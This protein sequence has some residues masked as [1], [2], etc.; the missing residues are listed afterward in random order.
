MR[1]FSTSLFLAVMVLTRAGNAMA[2]PIRVVTGPSSVGWASDGDTVFLVGNGF[3]IEAGQRF[4]ALPA[5]AGGGCLGTDIAGSAT[6]CRPGDLVNQSA[7]TGGEV[8]LGP[9]LA[10]IDGHDYG[11]VILRGALTFT[12]T[13]APFPTPSADTVFMRAPFVFDGLIRGF[14]DGREVFSL[15]LIG[16]GTTERSFFLVDD[17]FHY[18][19]ESGVSYRF[20]T[21]SVSPTP[22]PASLVLLATGMAALGAARRRARPANAPV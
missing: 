6:P 5:V 2:E 16:T 10:V 20:D 12:A 8:S 21:D 3:D 4:L 1:N 17:G 7:T 9:G 13:P 22:E 18:Q 15:G 11:D 14:Q 19:M